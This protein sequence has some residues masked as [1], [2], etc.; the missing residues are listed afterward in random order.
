MSELSIILSVALALAAVF[1]PIVVAIINNRH[2]AKMRI[3]D[4]KHQEEIKRMELLKQMEEIRFQKE[5]ETKREAF[6]KLIERASKYHSDMSNAS[7]L[8]VLY[9]SAYY[10]AS[11]CS[12][13]K[14]REV[15]NRFAES[16]N[17]KFKI[18]VNSN[19]ID[20]FSGELS[21]LSES[22]SEELFCNGNFSNFKDK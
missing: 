5:F 9:S 12:N 20:Y 18:D 19:T 2:A 8:D 10:S 14:C 15:I 11:V 22:L 17:H 21:I 16:A 3:A 7:A 13:E 4:F 1:S 6:S